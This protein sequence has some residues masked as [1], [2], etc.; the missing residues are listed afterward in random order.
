MIEIIKTAFRYH[1]KKRTMYEMLFS[2]KCRVE[3]KISNQTKKVLFGKE[4]VVLH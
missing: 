1:L 3:I 2:Q 4:C